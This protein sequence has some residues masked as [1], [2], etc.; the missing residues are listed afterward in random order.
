MNDLREWIVET[1][2]ASKILSDGLTPEIFE[3]FKTLKE[4]VHE[5]KYLEEENKYLEN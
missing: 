2:S 3:E 5:I 1:I 4:D